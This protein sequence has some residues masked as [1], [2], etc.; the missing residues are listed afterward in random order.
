MV[1]TFMQGVAEDVEMKQKSF[2]FNGVPTYSGLRCRC[3]VFLG[4][5][6]GTDAKIGGCVSRETL[7]MLCDVKPSMREHV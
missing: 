5:F 1:D 7:Q 6:K 4:V 3:I 2:V